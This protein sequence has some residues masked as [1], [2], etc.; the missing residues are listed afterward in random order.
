MSDIT[1]GSL[2]GLNTAWLIYAPGTDDPTFHHMLAEG[3]A[4]E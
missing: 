2:R 3:Y 4:N 1:A